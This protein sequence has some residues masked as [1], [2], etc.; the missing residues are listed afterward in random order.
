MGQM[1]RVQRLTFIMLVHLHNNALKQAYPCFC[2][3]CCF[4]IEKLQFKEANH[5]AQ[6]HIA[7][8][9]LA[10]VIEIGSFW[11]KS[12]CCF[13]YVMLPPNLSYFS[14]SIL[15]SMVIKLGCV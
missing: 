6:C 2:C 8:G 10:L 9:E 14:E 3:C 13:H 11:L 15:I 5:L 1:F 7:K 4:K 12:Y